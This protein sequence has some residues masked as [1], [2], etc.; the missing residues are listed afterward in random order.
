MHSNEYVQELTLDWDLAYIR[1]LTLRLQYAR[2]ANRPIHHRSVD[3]DPYLMSIQRKLPIL[4]STWNIYTF[5]PDIGVEPHV[6]GGRKCAVNIPV[7]NCESSSTI[8][9]KQTTVD[10]RVD[11]DR[12]LCSVSGTLE[13]VWQFTLTRPTLI[14]TEQP[15]SVTVGGLEP[16]VVFSWTV[17]D[18]SFESAKAHIS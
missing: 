18:L 17:K 16:R 15:H 3:Q 2:I 12:I 8:F 6:D 11:Q 5:Y 7:K 10:S 9:Y 13:P 4:S 1:E 14:N